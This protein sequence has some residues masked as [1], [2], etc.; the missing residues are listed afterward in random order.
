MTEFE[1]QLDDRITGSSCIKERLGTECNY[2]PDSGGSGGSGGSGSGSGSKPDGSY[3]DEK[4][5]QTGNPIKK[6]V[7]LMNPNYF[8]G[9]DHSKDCMTGCKRILDYYNVAYGDRN[10]VYQLLVERS[11][12]LVHYGS[13]PAENYVKAIACIDRHL[14]ANRPIIVGV[15]YKIGRTDN[16]GTTDHWIVVTGRG[17]DT[18]Q[19]L[20]YY[21]YINTGN[22]QDQIQA[23]CNTE[24]NRLYYNPYNLYFKD[25][26][27]Y[28]SRQLDVTQVRP[29]DGN[30]L[31]ETI[32]Q[33]S[34]NVE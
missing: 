22:L 16:E 31:S 7:E 6:N 30:Y 8:Y 17:Y 5:P 4:D 15:N 28:R 9:F 10:H 27:D 13:N 32:T 18:S 23:A 14:E 2:V 29:N 24:L 25:D 3:E 21:T 34:T 20:Y 33:P 1:D 19:K 26:Y 11:N 12:S